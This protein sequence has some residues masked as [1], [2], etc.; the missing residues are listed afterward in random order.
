MSFFIAALPLLLILFIDGMGVGLVFPLIN[1]LIV[2][3]ATDFLA[4]GT[5]ESTRSLLY[6]VI[7]GIFMI[8]WFFG[9]AILMVFY[10]PTQEGQP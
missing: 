8:C 10:H 3:P 2:G 6:G 1:S 5:T 4:A 7:I 9:A